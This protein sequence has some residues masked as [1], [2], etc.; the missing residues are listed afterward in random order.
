[1]LKFCP[2]CKEDKALSAFSK[3]KSMCKPCNVQKTTGYQRTL[4]GLVKKIYNNQLQ[5]SKKANRTPPTYTR[6]TLF[7]W[8]LQRN[9]TVMW[10]NWVDSNY[11]RWMSPSIDR[12]DNLK[13]YSLD[14]IQLVTWKDNL[15]NQKTMNILGTYLVPSSCGVK[16]LTKNGD[17]IQTFPS[18][19]I[20]ARAMTGTNQN[21]SN[22][23][24][25][26]RGKNKSAYGFCWQYA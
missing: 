17:Y 22:I 2:C 20:A 12:L 15:E 8:M 21:T 1:M 5:T 13:S 9:Y 25:V 7:E 23:S 14:N 6:D 16:Q 3:G 4:K 19:A 10:Q 18:I 26:C 24:N 11:E